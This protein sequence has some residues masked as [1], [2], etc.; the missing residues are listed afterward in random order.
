MNLSGYS[1]Q[2]CPYL[3]DVLNVVP[4]SH[5]VPQEKRRSVDY[6]GQHQ[7]LLS[8]WSLSVRNVIKV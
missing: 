7:E 6:L 4:S 3:L 2:E 8:V 5:V 1:G